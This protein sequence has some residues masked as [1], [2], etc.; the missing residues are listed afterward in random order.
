MNLYDFILKFAADHWF[1]AWCA[2]WLV[3]GGVPISSLLT[4]FVRYIVIR[5]TRAIMVSLRG[6]PPAHLDA[7]GDWRPAPKVETKTET[8]T[9]GNMS[10]T[11]AV[12]KSG[13]GN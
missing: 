1:L 2:L 3:W 7:D 10:H 13:A 9:A 4:T 6:W 5:I 11:T 8:A 12:T